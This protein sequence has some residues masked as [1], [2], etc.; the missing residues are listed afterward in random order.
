MT[1]VFELDATAAEARTTPS[2]AGAPILLD[3]PDYHLPGEE[4]CDALHIHIKIFQID[5]EVP[6]RG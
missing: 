6:A 2:N 1:M 4:G 5:E 3:Y